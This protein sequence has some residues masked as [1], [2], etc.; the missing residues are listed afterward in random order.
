MTIRI[1]TEIMFATPLG[2]TT[3]PK[4]FCNNF[5]SLKGAVQGKETDFDV[6]KHLP[7]VK[8][9][10]TDLFTIWVNNA[11]SYPNQKWKMLTNWI[12]DNPDGTRM[13]RHR[14]YNCAFSAVL[15][16]DEV[17]NG[18]GNLNLINPQDNSD[19]FPM[20]SNREQ[21]IFNT[22][23]YT[24]P[25]AEGLIIFFPAA[26]AHQYSAYKPNKKKPMRRSFACNFAPIGKY[27][28]GDSYIDTNWLQ[29]EEL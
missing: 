19:F 14:H 21:T 15:Y 29:H 7:K 1:E 6:I 22:N 2:I 26:I 5:K 13:I 10:I 11:Y 4:E 3:M 9:E 12:T 27:G 16:F 8:K 18:Q 28:I 25:L 23:I 20:S 24:A 17:T